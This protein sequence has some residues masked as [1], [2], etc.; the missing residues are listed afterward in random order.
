MEHVSVLKDESI[1]G[2]NLKPGYTFVDMTLGSGGHSKCVFESVK[3]LQIIG[4]DA[5][6]DAIKRAGKV[7]ASIGA[8]PILINQNFSSLEKELEKRGISRVDAILF[9]LG[10]SSVQLDD[11]GRGFTFRKDEPLLMTLTDDVVPETLTAENIVNNWDRETLETIIKGFGE[12]KYARS[13]ARAITESRKIKPIKTTFELVEAIRSGVPTRYT[14]QKIHFATRTFQ[15]LR[16]AVNDELNSL[17]KGLED[18]FRRLSI[19]GRISVISFHSL[20][21]RIVKNFNK[22]KEQQG[23]ANIHTKKPITPSEKEILDN[24]RSR[25]AKLRVIEKIK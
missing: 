1:L 9:D 25:S 4:F 21:D 11:S 8:K 2:L 13:I 20:E 17:K 5:D 15:A 18:G 22:E 23:L 24:P 3:D 10:I 7:L 6:G 16:I 19:G 12:E 14:H